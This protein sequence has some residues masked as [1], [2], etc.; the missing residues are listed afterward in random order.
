M[1]A[2]MLPRKMT[3]LWN[4]I[5]WWNGTRTVTTK[6]L[7]EGLERLKRLIRLLPRL[8]TVVLVGAK[9][10]RAKPYLEATVWPCSHPITL[11]RLLDGAG[12]KGWRAIPR[13]WAKV[14]FHRKRDPQKGETDRSRL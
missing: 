11:R 5:P 12:P 10:L 4:V 8:R 9:A 13:Q 7:L 1:Q 6:E 3:V 14:G 2:A